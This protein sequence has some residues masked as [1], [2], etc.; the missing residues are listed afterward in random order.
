MPG[1]LKSLFSLVPWLSILIGSFGR[2]FNPLILAG[3]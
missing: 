1:L 3:V 2:S